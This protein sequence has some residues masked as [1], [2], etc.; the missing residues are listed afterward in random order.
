VVA[1]VGDYTRLLVPFSLAPDEYEYLQASGPITLSLPDKNILVPAE[2]YRENPAFDP[3]TRKISVE[4]AVDQSSA[5]GGLQN[6]RGG[7]RAELAISL[8]D[9]SGAVLVPKSAVIERY[10]EFYIVREGG[11]RVKVVV[12]GPGPADTLRVSAEEVCP[13]ERFKR[14]NNPAAGG[15]EPESQIGG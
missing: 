1:T 6:M 14:K 12:L 11:E 5:A 13:G 7:L 10:E 8:P 4:L 15:Q 3:S 9:E 2:V